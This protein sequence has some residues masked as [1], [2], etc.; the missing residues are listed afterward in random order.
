MLKNWHHW[1][2]KYIKNLIQLLLFSKQTSWNRNTGHIHLKTTHSLA[3][4]FHVG[5]SFANYR[6]CILATQQSAQLVNSTY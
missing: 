5:T 2:S 1:L 4:S 3:H 6:T